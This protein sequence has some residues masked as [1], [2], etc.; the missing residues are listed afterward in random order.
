MQYVDLIY[1]ILR[2]AVF[3]IAL[4]YVDLQSTLRNDAHALLKFTI[5]RIV[6]VG[7]YFSECK[8]ILT[9]TPDL[10][11][12]KLVPSS[13]VISLF[14]FLPSIPAIYIKTIDRLIKLT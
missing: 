5:S 3:S 10:M 4:F 7:I 13:T 8:R 14:V 2:T 12:E 6:H 11:M 9:H 1:N